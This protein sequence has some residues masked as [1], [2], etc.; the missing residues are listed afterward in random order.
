MVEYSNVA[1]NETSPYVFLIWAIIGLGLLFVLYLVYQRYL[2]KQLVSRANDLILLEVKV[3]KKFERHEYESLKN[4]SEITSYTEQLFSSL[5][6]LYEGGLKGLFLGQPTISCE[7][8]AKE[9]EI[10]FFIG[11][12]RSL[13]SLVEKQIQS[14]YPN[15][16]IEPSSEFKIFEEGLEIAYGSV[17]TSRSFVF[18]IKTFRE[19]EFDSI[20]SITNALS[21][22]GNDSR[23]AVQ[24]LIKPVSQGWRGQIDWMLRRI[25]EGKG[26][27]LGVSWYNKIGYFFG[28]FFVS[29]MNAKDN[30]MQKVTPIQE[31]TLKLLTQ[32]GSKT[33]FSVQIKII[34]LSKT[35]Q[36]AEVNLKNIFSGFSQFSS[37]DRNGFRLYRGSDKNTFLTH[38]V[39]RTFLGYRR[40]LLNAEELASI[41]HFPTESLNTPG[42]RWF[43][44]KRAPAPANMPEEGVILGK[45]VYRGDETLVRLKTTDRRRH[46]Y[47]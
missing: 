44:A 39:L 16:N 37:P 45:N 26:I 24:I 34:T 27:P 19:L 5:G 35:K 29:Q 17:A 42:I 18:P 15:S 8:V 30:P 12:P 10:I 36:E 20:A 40:M 9:K 7:Y 11:V 2:K 25:Q 47:S 38:Y 46:L 14:F 21:K 31:E 41:Y 43:L 6:S 4:I 3:P 28:Q 1:S 22:I 33:G 23:A 32:K 13:Q